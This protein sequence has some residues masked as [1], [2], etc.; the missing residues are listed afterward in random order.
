MSNIRIF[1]VIMMLLTSIL[2]TGDATA[3]FS[4]AA[5][6]EN[7]LG[8]P[9]G[10]YFDPRNG[11]E[12]W[13]CP[14]G[15]PNRTAY[16]V[17]GSKACVQPAGESFAKAT[18]HRKYGCQGGFFDPRRGGECWKCPTD[19]PRRTAYAVTSDKACATKNI[20]GEKLAHAQ[21]MH[22]NSCD[23]GQFKDP[24]KGGECWS[25]PSGYNRT[26]Y[27]VDD[28]QGRA[29]VKSVPE[30][31]HAAQYVNKF[32]CPKGQF[33]DMRNGGECWSCPSNYYRTI[34]SVTSS[35]ACTDKPLD[36]LAIEG[37]SACKSIIEGFAAAKKGTDAVTARV[38]PFI[39]PVKKTL[40]DA[41][42]SLTSQLKS[43]AELNRIIDK[44]A[45]SMNN[46]VWQEAMR[47]ESVMTKSRNEITALLLDPDLMC[48]GNF[49]AIDNKL[50]ALDLQPRLP[51]TAATDSWSGFL[52]P[53]AQAA[54]DSRHFFLYL[55]FDV[56]VAQKE[57][58]MTSTV[59]I[60]TDF[61]GTG[62][63]YLGGGWA[64][65]TVDGVVPSFGFMLFPYNSISDFDFDFMAPIPT[66]GINLGIGEPV[67]RLLQM[68]MIPEGAGARLPDGFNVAYPLNFQSGP[69]F[70]FSK[71]VLSENKNPLL[72]DVNG[73]ITWSGALIKWGDH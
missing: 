24:R 22:K 34:N 48:E 45:A 40:D 26:A 71:S 9:A 66:A 42:N 4:S 13:K 17:D 19:K 60:I 72:I 21:F 18:Y 47:L 27:S 28:S 70:G 3:R 44:L 73:S 23:T 14:V 35:K 10:S 63:I 30:Q 39:D 32:A 11:G 67:K 8:C 5:Q 20:L 49:K 2:W 64:P 69:G 62:G 68:A 15:Y 25:C 33:L 12:C 50:K 52:I 61:R 29:C 58:A 54:A 65:G 16:P 38:K 53:S 55:S 41:T 6:H 51:A 46:D 36:I 56:L 7:A 57:K 43:P 31:L 37:G 1:L 59:A